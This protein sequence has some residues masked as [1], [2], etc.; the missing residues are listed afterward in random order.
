MKKTLQQQIVGLKARFD[1]QVTQLNLD[2]SGANAAFKELEE[3]L[4]AL[5]TKRARDYE[6]FCDHARR[7]ES[8]LG[9]VE[10]K[11][12][13][14]VKSFAGLY[15]ILDTLKTCVL[16]H[17]LPRLKLESDAGRRH[18][19]ELNQ[20]VE[21][22]RT[23]LVAHVE[24]HEVHDAVKQSK[25]E[26]DAAQTRLAAVQKEPSAWHMAEHVEQLRQELSE[27]TEELERLR[28]VP[29]SD[30]YEREMDSVD[31][32]YEREK[33]ERQMTASEADTVTEYRS[34][35]L[36]NRTAAYERLRAHLD[37]LVGDVEIYRKQ[38]DAVLNSRK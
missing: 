23:L 38:L 25:V 26:Y 16:D 18:F 9:E 10:Y 37:A 33:G 21:K 1:A 27:T 29:V 36:R 13:G 8:R 30:E 24:L 12:A 11:C 7:V 19:D 31:L 14:T 17:E 3:R 32:D 15:T 5:M 34:Q 6:L 22:L 4:G 28:N 35:D 2:R 20:Q